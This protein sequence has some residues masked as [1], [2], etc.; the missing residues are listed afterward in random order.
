MMMMMMMMMMFI[1]IVM[2]IIMMIIVI[3][4]LVGLGPAIQVLNPP[5]PGDPKESPKTR[6]PSAP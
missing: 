2:I 4:F 3:M 5:S 1:I 6:N